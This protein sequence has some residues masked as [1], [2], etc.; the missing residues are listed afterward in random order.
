MINIL[1]PIKMSRTND[2]ERR[3]T[4]LVLSHLSAL[5]FAGAVLRARH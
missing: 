1:L 5:G 2:K 3:P 4:P